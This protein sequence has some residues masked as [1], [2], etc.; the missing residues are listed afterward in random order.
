VQLLKT[1]MLRAMGAID[2]LVDSNR[3]NMQLLASVPALLLLTGGSRLIGALV[4][5]LSTRGLRSMRAVHSEMG[6]L[7]TR[8]ERCLTLAGSP[9]PQPPSS[10]LGSQGSARDSALGGRGSARDSALGGRGS[11]RD[12]ALG[13]RGSARDSAL[14]GRGSA[15]DS[16]L[17]GRGSARDSVR[18]EWDDVDYEMAIRGDQGGAIRG[19]QRPS[20][21][22]L[23]HSPHEREDVHED[24]AVMGHGTRVLQG[25]ELGEF[26]LHV[27][28]Y[29]LLLDYS[30][31][32]YASKACDALHNELQDLLRRGGL[33]VT[34]QAALLAA[35][36][37]RHVALGNSLPR[38]RL[39]L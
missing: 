11:A 10:A 22:S 20:D 3:L 17:G 29:L 4:H 19:D 5:R 12:S 7:L 15:R 2:S 26:A 16:A 38:R 35:V 28:S 30:S 14:G 13:G 8:L 24:E 36:K 37:E 34:Q 18:A 39:V 32:A 33:S 9:R 23:N 6:G 25:A 31:P 1:E 21:E 27:H